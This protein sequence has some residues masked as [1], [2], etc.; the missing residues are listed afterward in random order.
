MRLTNFHRDTFVRAVE[1][2]TPEVK[3]PLAADIQK[4]ILEK[5]DPR[6][7]AVYEDEKL[8]NLL[9]REYC[10]WASDHGHS[11]RYVTG[12]GVNVTELLRDKIKAAEARRQA[13]SKVRQAA[14]RCST[15]KQL[16]EALPELKEY[17]P[18][19]TGKPST[20]AVPMAVGV[21]DDLKKAGFPK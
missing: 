16:E 7:R 20:K 5:M 18:T 4:M 14:D 15:L 21:F 1:A 10:E 13:I 11:W 9:N 19:D 12:G 2:D 17:M 3:F 6:V 8:R